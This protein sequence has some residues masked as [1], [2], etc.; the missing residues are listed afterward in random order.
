MVPADQNALAARQATRTTPI[1]MVGDPVGSGLAASLG[2]PGGNVTGVSALVGYEIIG[3]RLELL[4]TLVP[5]LSRVTVLSNPDNPSHAEGLREARTGAR[6]LGLEVHVLEARRSEDLV[7]AF[8][9]TSRWRGGAVL[10]LGDGMFGLQRARIA[11]LAVKSRLATVHATAGMV[12]AGGLASYGASY[13]DLFR[14][15]ARYVDRILKGARPED[16]STSRPP[17]RLAS[18]FRPRCWRRRTGSS[19]EQTAPAPGRSWR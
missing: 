15:A 1:V 18:R 4:R 19:S 8:E 14:R 9:S 6:S 12:V 13:P 17:R 10:V 7:G 11:D 2:R 5:G 16:R 3:K